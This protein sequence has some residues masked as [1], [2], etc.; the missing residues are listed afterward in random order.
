MND[1]QKEMIDTGTV[2]IFPWRP[3]PI[4]PFFFIQGVIPTH[5]TP[6]SGMASLTADLTCA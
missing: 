6:L 5:P 2:P 1:Y 3:P 4:I